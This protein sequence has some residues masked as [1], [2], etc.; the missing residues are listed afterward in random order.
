MGAY[1]CLKV[2][3]NVLVMFA[4]YRFHCAV[5]PAVSHLLWDFAKVQQIESLIAIVILFVEV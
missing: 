2:N 4:A 5:A 1:M 3:A